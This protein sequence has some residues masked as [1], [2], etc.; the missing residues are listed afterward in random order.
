MAT[1]RKE[2]QMEFVRILYLLDQAHREAIESKQ[3]SIADCIT[4]VMHQTTQ[5]MM[6]EQ[7]WVKK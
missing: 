1:S 7:G 3:N 2:K 5:L 6:L 4:I